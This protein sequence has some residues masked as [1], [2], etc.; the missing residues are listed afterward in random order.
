MPITKVKFPRPGINKQDTLYGAEGGWTDCDNMRFRYG[1]P[2]KIGGWQ[3]VAPP[4]HLIGVARDIHNYNDLAGDSLCAI[5]T[6]RKLYIY[7][8]N[9]Y[10][11]VTP[12]STTI[13]AT[14]SFTSGTTYVDVTAT[15][16]GAV[17]GDFVTFSGVTGVSVGSSTITNTTMSQEFEIQEIKTANIF[18][19]NVA[20][21]G[22]PTLN[23]TASATSAAFQINVGADTTQ[24]GIGWGAASW[25]FST[26]GTPRPTG[27]ITQNPRIWALDN[28]GEDLIAT[29]VGGKTYYLQTSTFI[30]PRNTRATLLANAPT[31]SNYMVVSSRDRH[32]IF[33]G[34]E[35]TPGTTTT[36]DPMA[37]LFGSQ[38]SIT[39]FVPT[40][41]NTAGF[42]RLSSGNDIVTAVRTRGDL[43]LL[44]NTSAHQMQFVGPPYTFSFK[45]TGTNCGAISP[46]CAVE[47]ENV[48]Y[49]MSNGGFFLFDGVVKQIPC[50]V[51]DYVYSDIDDEEQ[52]TTYAGVNLQ[53]AEVSWF[54]ASQNSNYI[55]RMVTYNYREQVWTIGTLARTV[56]APR[57]I[58]AYPLAAD[59]DVNSTSQAQP[60]VIGL[61]AG[62]STLY[63]QEYGN[64]ADG[65]FLPAYIQ[66]AEFAIGDSN[67]SMFIKRYIPD[68]KNQVGGVQMEF[69]VRQYPG[70]VQTV[71][72][73]TVVYSTTTKVDMRSRARQVA[74][75]MSTVDS[76]TSTATTFRFGTL[77]IDAQPDGTR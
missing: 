18:T 69:L 38:E 59:Y 66:T 13:A 76:G 41:V 42:Q 21:L 64:Q 77:R 55:N 28:W 63:N 58:F 34:T 53:F 49:W 60:T 50:S 35:T 31:Q 57:D 27:V 73:S 47:A 2:E 45:Q 6:D 65:A 17:M 67:D 32:L 8:D 7:Y 26:W 56:W 40:S 74:I 19:I 48:I 70:S 30:I 43:L 9:N 68:F 46:H 11:D 23:D 20:E 62:R 10:Y 4:L 29:I 16:N 15:S 3:N 72:S 39:D 52:G 44:T 61:T 36:Y 33:L 25:G 14:F 5:G 54:Y 51:Q 1:I 71:G 37:V 22:T 75:K 12:L 24:L